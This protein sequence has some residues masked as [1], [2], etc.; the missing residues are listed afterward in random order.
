M[1]FFPS[2]VLV[3]QNNQF[4]EEKAIEKRGGG[5]RKEKLDLNKLQTVTYTSQLFLKV[6]NL[7][8]TESKIYSSSR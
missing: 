7:D 4:G 6:L 3:S 8:S 5:E 1:C 2:H